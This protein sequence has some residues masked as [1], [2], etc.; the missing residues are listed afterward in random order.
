MLKL[1]RHGLKDERGAI[2]LVSAFALI[3]ILGFSALVVDVGTFYIADIRLSNGVDAAA[4]AG[5][6][7]LV[8]SA[9]EARTTAME[10]AAK[11]GLD[12]DNIDIYISPDRASITVESRKEAPILFGKILVDEKSLLLQKNATA[13]VGSI[14]AMSGVVPLGLVN[15]ELVFGQ[16]YIIKNAS[17]NNYDVGL[18]AGNF[19]A[20]AL[21]EGRGASNFERHLTEGYPGVISVGDILDTEP[22]NMSNPT[23]RAIDKR[24]ARA[25]STSYIDVPRGC[26]RVVIVPM[27]EPY[28]NKSGRRKVQVVGFS[29]FWL[30]GVTGQG[31]NSYIRGYFLERVENGEISPEAID[32]GVKAVKLK[33]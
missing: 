5:A 11:N 12:S 6:Q 7:D 27:L 13:M 22:G 26:P 29:A 31:N 16:K 20:L 4:L 8:I 1:F 10:Y 25:L 19:G 28:D 18:G 32:Y 9:A 3:V 23:K 33:H 17:S 24:I 21:G 2:N 14:G 30:D 15:R